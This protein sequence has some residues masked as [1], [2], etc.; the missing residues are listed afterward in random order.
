MHLLYKY[1]LASIS[2]L[3]EILKCHPSICMQQ[4]AKYSKIK[5]PELM[6]GV[7]VKLEAAKC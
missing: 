4:Y 2:A 7:L 1:L 5:L 6:G 3:A